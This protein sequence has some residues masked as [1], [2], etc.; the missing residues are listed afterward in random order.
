MT[1]HW[2]YKPEWEEGGA[3]HLYD[4]PFDI[5]M[6]AVIVQDLPRSLLLRIFIDCFSTT[7]ITELC[8]EMVSCPQS[9]HNLKKPQEKHQHQLLEKSSP[10]F[11]YKR[12]PLYS[13]LFL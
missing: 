6:L 5:S 10:S 7:L 3:M 2:W 1:L 4:I 9:A 8:K 11:R 12:T 13:S